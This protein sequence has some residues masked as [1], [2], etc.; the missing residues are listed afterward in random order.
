[1]YVY[2]EVTNWYLKMGLKNFVG[3]GLEMRGSFGTYPTHSNKKE[4]GNCQYQTSQYYFQPKFYLN[5][6]IYSIYEDK[7][8]C[9]YKE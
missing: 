3:R 2:Y 4:K 7:R 9:N 6:I 1:M 8:N 5:Y